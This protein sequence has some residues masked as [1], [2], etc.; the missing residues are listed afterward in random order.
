MLWAVK[1]IASPSLVHYTRLL[2]MEIDLM[3]WSFLQR[4]IARLRLH[5]FLW[6]VASFS[7]SL[8]PRLPRDIH[9][10]SSILSS[11]RVDT[12]T[13]ELHHGRRPCVLFFF[14]Q[15][16]AGGGELLGCRDYYASC[17]SVLA[18]SG[19]HTT[20]PFTSSLHRALALS[21]ATPLITPLGILIHFFC[22]PLLIFWLLAHK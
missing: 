16:C 20:F 11:H 10:A 12:A 17:R 19:F 6:R 5:S 7:S 14:L 18:S 3:A 22:F 13:A 15:W 8:L 1:M 9:A 2:R 4:N 21:W